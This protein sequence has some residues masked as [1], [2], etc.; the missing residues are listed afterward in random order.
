M[1]ATMTFEGGW[2]ITWHSRAPD[3]PFARVPETALQ[4]LKR[5]WG[6]LSVNSRAILPRKLR[7]CIATNVKSVRTGADLIVLSEKL[8]QPLR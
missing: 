8:P 1:L 7:L 3:N 6:L 4:S 2:E 5:W